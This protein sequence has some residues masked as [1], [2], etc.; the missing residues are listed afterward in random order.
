[1][2]VR[3]W[4]VA[5]THTAHPGSRVSL[6]R[7]PTSRAGD[8][9]AGEGVQDP[10]YAAIPRRT[11]CCDSRHARWRSRHSARAP[12]VSLRSSPGW[13]GG[14]ILIGSPPSVWTWCLGE[15]TD[16]EW[17][18]AS[19]RGPAGRVAAQTRRLETAGRGGHRTVAVRMRHSRLLRVRRTTPAAE[20]ATPV[21]QRAWGD[22]CRQRSP[23][24]LMQRHVHRARTAGN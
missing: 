20:Q 1:M 23:E 9:P 22:E 7:A 17:A 4:R 19:N 2:K 15:N 13:S 3:P 6:T 8:A 11:A 16:H 18:W 21:P 5:I 12:R 14:C 24:T 10:A